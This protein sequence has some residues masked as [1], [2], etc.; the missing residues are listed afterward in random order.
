MRSAAE[1]VLL[2]SDKKHQQEQVEA[3]QDQEVRR[4]PSRRRSQ[5]QGSPVVV[6]P[7]D[8]PPA[9]GSKRQRTSKDPV[10]ASLKGASS[11]R[12]TSRAPPML[13]EDVAMN[14]SKESTI[15]VAEG[16]HRHHDHE[17]P[18][19]P[20]HIGDNNLLQPSDNGKAGL[21]EVPL[22]EVLDPQEEGSSRP[23][24]PCVNT[25]I[26][27]AKAQGGSAI[28]TTVSVATDIAAKRPVEPHSQG[29]HGEAQKGRPSSCG[30]GE[31]HYFTDK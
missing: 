26:H 8:G 29:G 7:Q 19:S 24:G 13:P 5:P 10:L 9:T 3:G 31:G 11:H 23:S 28:P 30:T 16:V 15:D 1:A 17:A 25:A 27:T 14:V 20:G 12:R 21:D 22:E 6:R 18:A 4:H 2:A